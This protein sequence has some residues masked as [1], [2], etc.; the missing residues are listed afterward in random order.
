MEGRRA[1][2]L[3]QAAQPD[4]EVRRRIAERRERAPES[5]AADLSQTPTGQAVRRK[6]ERTI[7]PFQSNEPPALNPETRVV[8]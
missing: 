4:P 6:L 8:A 1:T 7:V 5:A 2:I 3:S